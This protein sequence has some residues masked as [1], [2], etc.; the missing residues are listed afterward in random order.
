MIFFVAPEVSLSSYYLN[1]QIIHCKSATVLDSGGNYFL[2]R[3]DFH[4]QLV[5]EQPIWENLSF[6]RSQESGGLVPGLCYFSCLVEE[7][8]MLQ[9]RKEDV[10]K[11]RLD[12]ERNVCRTESHEAGVPFSGLHYQ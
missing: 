1:R 11:Q 7:P 6:F 10:L 9:E 4:W 5:S 12:D 3:Q 2:R 8:E